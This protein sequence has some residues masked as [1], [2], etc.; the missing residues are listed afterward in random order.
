MLL[1]CICKLRHGGSAEPAL[2]AATEVRPVR[3]KEKK[4][5]VSIKVH[6]CFIALKGRRLPYR[7]LV[8][9]LIP[10]RLSRVKDQ[11]EDHGY[12]GQESPTSQ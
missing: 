6:S 9:K 11:A 7:I 8:I 5:Y 1:T 12:T 10:Q 4:S 2:P 3:E